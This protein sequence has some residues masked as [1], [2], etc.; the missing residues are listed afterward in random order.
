ML[1][2][3]YTAQAI[4]FILNAA[5]LVFDCC[6]L[7]AC[8]KRKFLNE[9]K[10]DSPIVYISFMAVFGICEKL[11]AFSMA[12]AWPIADWIEPEKGYE[13][14]PKQLLL[15]I[16][17]NPV[18]GSSTINQ[19]DKCHHLLRGDQINTTNGD[20]GKS[21]QRGS[22]IFSYVS[23]ARRPPVKKTYPDEPDILEH[24]IQHA[25]FKKNLDSAAGSGG[26]R[27]PRGH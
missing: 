2:L 10:S 17:C 16:S 26:R 15:R 12:C 5:C 19:Y 4:F 23:S 8:I 18:F 1:W 6:L 9:K 21:Q 27:R 13:R 14:Q 20:L 3:A 24:D 11:P 25:N 7:Y 22:R